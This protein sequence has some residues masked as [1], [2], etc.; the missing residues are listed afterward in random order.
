MTLSRNRQPY[1]HRRNSHPHHDG[2]VAFSS[3]RVMSARDPPG[4]RAMR[5]L[6][7]GQQ[8]A[9]AAEAL[10]DLPGTQC[11]WFYR[12]LGVIAPI[13][14][15]PEC[16]DAACHAIRRA[17]HSRSSG[18]RLSLHPRTPAS[19]R[20]TSGSSRLFCWRRLRALCVWF[21]VRTV[22]HRPLRRLQEGTQH[23]AEGELGYQIPVE[24][25]DELGALASALTA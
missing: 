5:R 18:H 16:S 24:S 22:L 4:Q 7:P 17:T 10:S 2:R 6:P 9:H 12:V 8:P 13:V 25:A 11:R 23:L 15:K 3:D 19:R 20:A 21:A 1:R 14:N